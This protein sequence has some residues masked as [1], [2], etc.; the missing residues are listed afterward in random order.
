MNQRDAVVTTILAVLQERGYEYELNG[1]TAI[2]DVLTDSDKKSVRDAIF[3]MFR[4][5][6][7]DMTADAKEK[8]A[9]DKALKGYVSGLVNNWIRKAPEFNS[10]N[11]YQA[12]NPG[13]RQGSSDAQVQEMKKLL[14][15]T[16]DPHTKATIQAEIDARVA[17]LKPKVE[18]DI[19]KLPESLR[20]LVK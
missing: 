15:L 20:S 2:A 7:I 4:A 13:S 19:S 3:T 1:P 18:V 16:S 6:H 11:T 9:D 8:Y 5:G 14:K 17:E 10:G 12:K